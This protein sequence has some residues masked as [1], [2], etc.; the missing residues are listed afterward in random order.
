MAQCNSLDKNNLLKFC[1][2]NC[3]G[4]SEFK[5]RKDVFDFLRKQECSIYFLQE[6][7]F[8]HK[9]ENVIGSGWGFFTFLHTSTDQNL[10]FTFLHTSTDQNLSFTF[11]HTSTDQNLSFTFLHTST[12]QNISFTFLH[13]S[14]DQNLSF[15]FL[16]TSTD[17]NLLFTFLHTFP[18]ANFKKYSKSSSIFT[19]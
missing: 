7:H 4:L 15:T 10:S 2:F 14:K 17:Q 13:T 16:H 19:S 6:T 3:N 1:T 18:D 5:K 12:D 9:C 8:L 11:L